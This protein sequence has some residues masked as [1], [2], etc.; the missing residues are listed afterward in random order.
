[1]KYIVL[2][3]I[4]I[5]WCFLHS[6]MISVTVAEYFKRSLGSQFRFSVAEIQNKDPVTKQLSAKKL[7]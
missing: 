1:M 7:S 4:V 2:S 3:V 5:A 6:A